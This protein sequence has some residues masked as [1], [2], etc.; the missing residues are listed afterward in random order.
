MLLSYILNESKI[1]KKLMCLLFFAFMI[2]SFQQTYSMQAA[3]G[4]T[5][6]QAAKHFAKKGFSGI[7]TTLHWGIAAGGAFLEGAKIT[8]AL[9]DEN[10]NV[11]GYDHVNNEVHDFVAQEIKLL[12]PA[13]RLD[14][15]RSRSCHN[16][17]M[18][19]T[20]H[21][22]LMGQNVANEI[23]KALK[24]NDEKT[25]NKWRAVL[26]HEN[27][28]TK[29]EDLIVR[30]AVSFATP[31]ITHGSLRMLRN[32]LPF[33]KKIRSFCKEEF[34]K[35]PT[36]LGKCI[37]NDTNRAAIYRY[38]EEQADLGIKDEFVYLNGMKEFL[39]EHEQKAQEQVHIPLQKN[40][41]MSSIS[42][43]NLQ[44]VINLFTTHPPTENRI[45]KIE[46]RISALDKK[47]QQN[48]EQ[49]THEMNSN[50]REQHN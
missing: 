34:L 23:D 16:D 17:T 15:V 4:R 32:A 42:Y 14:S 3:A 1:M 6:A 46:Q 28:H 36:G 18:G 22:I 40:L 44:K 41:N 10:K 11:Q 27:E 50:Y 2:T 5:A 38:Q 12:S 30:A 48:W 43:K 33:A 9:L 25:L 31:F 35:I 26:Q 13:V 24:E 47:E 7:M 20:R 39:N 19:C 37:I 49:C 29:N 45:A 8:K 21:H